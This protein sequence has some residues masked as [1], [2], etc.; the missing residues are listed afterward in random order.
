MLNHTHIQKHTGTHKNIHS[1]TTYSNTNTHT[2]TFDS[3]EKYTEVQTQAL[4]HKI[5]KYTFIPN[6]LK[7][8]HNHLHTKNRVLPTNTIKSKH[9]NT[10][11][12]LQTNTCTFTRCLWCLKKGNYFDLEYPKDGLF[13]LIVLQVCY[14][15]FPYNSIKPNFRFL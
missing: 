13:N 11:T 9:T 4:Q 14:S 15:V 12:K 1:H 6:I 8:T 5:N 2:Q 10:L 7:N 3:D